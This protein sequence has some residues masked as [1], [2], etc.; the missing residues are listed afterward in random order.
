MIGVY[1]ELILKYDENV[2]VTVSAFK[3]QVLTGR[4]GLITPFVKHVILTV[5]SSL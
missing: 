1:I 3:V 2:Y 4:I 5:L